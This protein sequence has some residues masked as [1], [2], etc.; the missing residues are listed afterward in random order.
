LEKVELPPY[1]DGC[2]EP[3]S[4]TDCDYPET[5]LKKVVS[6]DWSKSGSPAVD[7]VKN[8][9]WTNEDQNTVAKYISEDKMDPQEAAEKWVADNPD[10]V[11]AWL[12]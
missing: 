12:G 2:Q 1:K 7:L 11:Q 3:P 9:E 4:A 8:F 5:V 10:K 6:T